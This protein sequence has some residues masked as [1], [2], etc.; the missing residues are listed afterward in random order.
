MVGQWAALCGEPGI[1]GLYTRKVVQFPGHDAQSSIFKPNENIESLEHGIMSQEPT[2]DV[3]CKTL[4][5]LT[6]YSQTVWGR[7][8]DFLQL[9]LQ[10]AEYS[11]L[12]GARNLQGVR[13]ISVEATERQVYGNESEVPPAAR[14]WQLLTS[15]GF[16]KVVGTRHREA[17]SDTLWV[18]ADLI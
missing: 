9:D 17:S 16:K 15:R 7:G 11:V 6:N 8:L 2:I 5:E 10:G 3:Q 12:K 13:A 14:L 1:V 18:R 4:D